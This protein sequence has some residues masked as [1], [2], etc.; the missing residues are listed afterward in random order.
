MTIFARCQKANLHT[1][2][3]QTLRKMVNNLLE[4][5]VVFTCNSKTNHWLLYGVPSRQK[6]CVVCMQNHV[7]CVCSFVR[8]VCT[9]VQRV[10]SFVVCV[11]SFCGV[12]MQFLWCVYAAFNRSHPHFCEDFSFVWN[13]G[14]CR[15]AYWPMPRDGRT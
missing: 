4:Q 14:V 5:S 2:M 7:W 11:G 13:M 3:L 10:C 8:R 12:C 9:F 15:E 1:H 6:L